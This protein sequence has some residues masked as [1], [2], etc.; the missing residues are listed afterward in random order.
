[1][2]ARLSV[3]HHRYTV[4]LTETMFYFSKTGHEYGV[5]HGITTEACW[6][7]HLVRSF[8]PTLNAQELL[9]LG[10]VYV[11]NERQTQDAYLPPQRQFRLHTRP[12][13]FSLS[14]PANHEI[15]VYENS[16]FLIVDKPADWPMHATVDNLNENLLQYLRATVQAGTFAGTTAPYLLT[17]RLDTGTR[18]LVF[19][20][21]TPAAQRNFNKNLQEQTV[22]KTYLALTTAPTS[23]G[24]HIHFL[25][26]SP[27]APKEMRLKPDVTGE[28][29]ECQLI[30]ESSDQI[31][32]ANSSVPLWL[33]QIRLLT[34][35]T[36][37]I[38]AQLA[39]M[40]APICGDSLYGQN[41][42]A[43]THLALACI[44]LQF[45]LQDQKW[46]FSIGK[47]TIVQSWLPPS[48]VKNES[49]KSQDRDLTNDPYNLN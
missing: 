23:L 39:A 42:S 43:S 5:I 47:N 6:I 24:L 9:A 8:D 26:V 37:Q 2:R 15:K 1:M 19:F 46:H 41:S 18:G 29:L 35:R 25:R 34:G 30:V 28:W 14:L 4:L 3:E 38:R 13:R 49:V 22:R 17:H 16:Q 20:A 7:S 27:K 32:T 44:D 40:A 48:P 12:R 31:L 10:A 45:V 33:N 21:K 36:H 11:E